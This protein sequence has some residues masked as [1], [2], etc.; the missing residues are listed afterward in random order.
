MD[1]T[2][3]YFYKSKGLEDPGRSREDPG[4]SGDY[5]HG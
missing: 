2:G 4:R 1:R 3:V 5:A